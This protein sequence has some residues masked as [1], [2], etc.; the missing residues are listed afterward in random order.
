MKSARYEF[1]L[2]LMSV[3][4][5]G[6]GGSESTPTRQNKSETAASE[7]VFDPMVQTIDKAK[8]VEDLSAD[9]TRELDKELEKSQ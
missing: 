1:V 5:A 6:C 9:R 4:T 3:W 8:S 2:I 7:S